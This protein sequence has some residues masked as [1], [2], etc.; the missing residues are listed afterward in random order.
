M[1][2]FKSSQPQHTKSRTNY[3]KWL[4]GRRIPVPLTYPNRGCGYRRIRLVKPRG[5]VTAW[6]KPRFLRSGICASLVS[7]AVR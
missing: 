2:R 7:L 4:I 5:I 6:P 3:V 1:P